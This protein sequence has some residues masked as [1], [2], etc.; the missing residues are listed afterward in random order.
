MGVQFPLDTVKAFHY[1]LKKNFETLRF[2]ASWME[3]ESF[4]IHFYVATRLWRYLVMPWGVRCEAPWFLRCAR[5]E[6][7]T[8]GRPSVLF[9]AL[10]TLVINVPLTSLTNKNGDRHRAGSISVTER[11][12]SLFPLRPLLH[13]KQSSASLPYRTR[14]QSIT[15]SNKISQPMTKLIIKKKE[16]LRARDDQWLKRHVKCPMSYGTLFFF[17]LNRIFNF[18]I[19]CDSFLVW[20]NWLS[21]C[22]AGKWTQRHLFF[23]ERGTWHWKSLVELLKIQM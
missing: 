1:I 23:L 14:V 4:E 13:S 11:C 6:L 16:K 5:L 17:F 8:F 18:F 10:E 3:A 7:R 12:P 2:S 21:P 19:C 22:P 15:A 9:T 20:H